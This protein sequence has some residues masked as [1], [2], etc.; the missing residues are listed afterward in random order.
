[1]P[2]LTSQQLFLPIV[3]SLILIA[4]T[5]VHV[6]YAWVK[7]HQIPCAFR[8]DQI[9][10]MM[11]S[12]AVAAGTISKGAIT[13]KLRSG[14]GKWMDWNRRYF[15][16]HYNSRQKQIRLSWQV[17]CST[18]IKAV[19]TGVHEGAH[20]LHHLSL[21]S[22]GW[23]FHLPVISKYM[24]VIWMPLVLSL[25]GAGEAL[26]VS[27]V[28]VL[29]VLTPSLPADFMILILPKSLS[30]LD[31]LLGLGVVICLGQGVSLWME[32]TATRNGLAFLKNYPQVDLEAVQHWL[33][34]ALGTYISFAFICSS[35]LIRLAWWA[36][37]SL[38]LL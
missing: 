27:L 38:F 7:Y 23:L 29:L 37:Q 17:A 36:R 21:G 25:I 31:T 20:G 24:A 4:L 19:G 8:G 30:I 6:S 14:W 33:L 10:R 28:D 15:G 5:L 26:L 16:D 11:L 9:T 34:A 2:Q 13:V 18:S 32:I 35:V 3:P 12:T 22:L 1:M